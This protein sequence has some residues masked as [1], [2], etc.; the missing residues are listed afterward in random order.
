M[1]EDGK[2]NREALIS[3]VKDVWDFDNDS[4]KYLEKRTSDE[5]TPVP[6]WK[7]LVDKY[8]WEDQRIRIDIDM[9][10]EKCQSIF[11]NEDA[12]FK[13]FK[14]Y[15]KYGL[16]AL[17]KKYNT[18]IMYSEFISNKVVFKKNT[19]KIKKVLETIY[20]EDPEAFISD[21]ENYSFGSLPETYIV[22]AMEK[23]GTEKKSAKAK[24]QFVISFNLADW[25]LS[26]TAENKFT[27]C[28]NLAHTS[29]SGEPDGGYQYCL[30]LPFL[31]GDNNRAMLYVTDGEK[32]T[33]EGMTVDSVHSRTWSIVDKENKHVNVK[34]Y[35]VYSFTY[36]EI[37]SLLGDDSFIDYAEGSYS[38][39]H[40]YDERFA[41]GKYPFDMLTTKSGL[42]ISTYNDMG[43]LT[44]ENGRL[45]HSN[46]LE[47]TRHQTGQQVFA[48]GNKKLDENS[49][50][51]IS[52]RKI[53]DFV[54][55]YNFSYEI[56]TW[57][58]AGVNLDTCSPALKCSE[59]GSISHIGYITKASRYSS[60]FL[61]SSCYDK[62][63]YICDK[64]GS[65][66]LLR[67][68]EQKLVIKTKNGTMTVCP[69]CYQDM[70]KRICS[71]CGTYDE[72]A[73]KTI[74]GNIIC[75]DCA[76]EE[77]YVKCSTTGKFFKKGFSIYNPMKNK[78]NYYSVLPE[79]MDA[80]YKE[81][82]FGKDYHL[83]IRRINGV[84]GDVE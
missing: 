36:K 7:K 65:S 14:T 15:F 57:R 83:E 43:G 53:K 13:M 12:A 75:P 63:Y 80:D 10:N 41:G 8:G 34:W 23:I 33:F 70:A 2:K 19:T 68:G 25:M 31:A 47:G 11:Q 74:E 27:S 61:C 24:L 46:N 62:K 67:S 3:L 66:H 49:L 84:S 64:C 30:G 81:Y 22:K 78:C 35:P 18:S 6:E 39:A 76:K 4:M 54:S 72:N 9:S 82:S 71:I 58:K 60:Q 5:W 59:C 79:N 50:A 32:K 45:I 44:V 42:F 56:P 37:R 69:N 40:W 28:F 26:S 38:D 17:L 77:G 29:D 16:K 51:S 73:E 1:T 52:W 21:K 20:K 48:K 55:N